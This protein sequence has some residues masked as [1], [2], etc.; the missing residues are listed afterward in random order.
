MY[1]TDLDKSNQHRR[2]L[3]RM[4]SCRLAILLVDGKHEHIGANKGQ[5]GQ[6]IEDLKCLGTEHLFVVG[7]GNGALQH[8]P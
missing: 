1:R 2:L 6:F 5:T 3:M 4:M 7:L 8:L